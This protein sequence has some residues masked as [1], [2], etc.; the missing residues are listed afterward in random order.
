MSNSISRI[1]AETLRRASAESFDLLIL[2]GGIV[3][4]GVARDAAL[5]GLKTILVD[6][7]DFAFGTSSRSS[8]LLHGGIRYLAQGRVRLVREAS[9]EKTILHRIAPHLAEP[10]PFVFPAYREAADWPFWQLRIGVKIYDLLCGGRNLGRSGSL[11]TSQLGQELPELKQNGLLGAVRYF[12]GHTQDARL[13]LDTLRSARESGAALLNYARF[14]KSERRGGEFISNLV[15]TERGEPFQIRSASVVNATGPWSQSISGSKVQLRLTKGI[16]LVFSR[17]KLPVKEAV[18]ITE[19]TRVLFVIPW[20]ERLI[21]G[22]TDT[23]YQGSPEGARSDSADIEY[24][25]LTVARFFP[26]AHL[27]EQDIISS[28]AGLRPLLFD[29]K[30]GPSDISRSHQI[31]QSQANWWDV[32]GGKLTT[33]RLIAEQTVDQV[34][35]ALG[36]ATNRC[37]TADRPLLAPEKTDGISQIVPPPFSRRLVEHFCAEEWARHLDDVLMRRSSWHFYDGPRMDRAEQCAAWMGETLGWSDEEQK[38]EVQRYCDA[39]DFP[40]R[41]GSTNRSAPEALYA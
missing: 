21:I 3:G 37:A 18:V 25:L 7:H 41:G 14:E 32:A 28:W 6:Q 33:Y 19:G 29:P 9:V 26:G 22:T 13:V 4:A 12:D 5:R 15:E 16:H 35:G 31:R 24:L 20:G 17:E 40:V 1:R 30:R 11:N 8:R 23:D 34:A 39:S 38:R 27:G 36:R 2:G 10:L